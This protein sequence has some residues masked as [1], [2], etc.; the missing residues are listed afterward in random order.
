MG[1]SDTLPESG[2]SSYTYVE[3]RRYLEGLLASF[4][5]DRD[6][7]V[8]G[9]DWGSVLGFDWARR[10]PDIVRGVAFMEAIVQPITWDEWS[11][12]TRSFFEQLRSSAGEQMILQENRFVE[13][14][15]PRRIMRTLTDAEM[16]T[17]RRPFREPGESR[18]PTL[19]WPRQLPIEG[20]PVEVVAIVRANGA[21]LAESP[22]PKLFINAEP[23]TISLDER[24]FCRNW[25]N[26]SEAM[27]KGLH[28]IQEDSPDNIGEALASW[29][30]SLHLA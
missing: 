17:Y 25:R 1:D 3:H 11:P 4:G 12:Q 29:Y 21:W 23:G 7:T 13:S 27:V 6:V 8:V 2:P 30:T 9:H 24:Q 18:R 10:H 28:F 15:L 22:V 19:T 14:L 16:E 20:E 5:V 26:T